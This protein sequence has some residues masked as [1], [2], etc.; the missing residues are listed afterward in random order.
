MYWELG[1]LG[2]MRWEYLLCKGL[3]HYRSWRVAREFLPGMKPLPDA[4]FLADRAV[5]RKQLVHR[6]L[7]LL[8]THSVIFCVVVQMDEEI[9][10][11]SIF[12]WF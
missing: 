7:E 8:S 9:L 10:V 1:L 12:I 2:S 6:K 4:G 3:V 5:R 11:Q